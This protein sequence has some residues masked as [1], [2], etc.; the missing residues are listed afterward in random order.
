M[1]NLYN[2]RKQWFLDRVGKK[3]FRDKSFCDCEVCK[4][5]ESEGILISSDSHAL[6]LLDIESISNDPNES[7]H[8]IKYRDEK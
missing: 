2:E 5:V 7:N 4:R 3:V 8:P 6:Y 1:G